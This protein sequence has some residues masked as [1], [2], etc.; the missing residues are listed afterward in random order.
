MKK[1]EKIDYFLNNLFKWFKYNGRDFPWRHTSDPWKILLAEILLQ[2]TNAEKVV[3]VYNSLT[4]ALKTPESVLNYSADSV[5]S[6][7]KPL[8]L[9]YIKAERIIKLGKD[10]VDKFAGK[11]PL[12][13]NKLL[14]L[15]GVG[16][17]S[18]GMVTCLAGGGDAPAL[19]VNSIR[20]LQRFFSY[21]SEYSRLR[22]DP[23]L[24]KFA[25]SLIPANKCR[26]FN[27]AL[28][29]FSSKICRP[30]PLCSSCPLKSKC[31]FY[32]SH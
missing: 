30:S 6:I 7:L 9:E 31:S 15:K 3:S 32:L 5:V 18:A 23:N 28:I 19:D 24:R 8:G 20:V 1:S 29:D 2:K 14:E 21:K 12:E 26:E 22:T 17:Y 16:Y 10:I 27:L 11:V 25:K 4:A 13:I